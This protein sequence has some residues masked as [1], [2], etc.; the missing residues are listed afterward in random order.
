MVADTN[1]PKTIFLS[2]ASQDA[3]AAAGICA[4]LQSIGLIVWF[5]RGEL[6]GGDAWDASIR[7]QIKECCLFLPIISANTESRLE[8]YFRREWNL[9]AARMLDM[10]DHQAFL[11]PIIIDDTSE[12]NAH[13]PD[14]FRERQ[15]VRLT[16]GQALA[17]LVKRVDQL[18]AGG[19]SSPLTPAYSAPVAASSHNRFST[20]RRIALAIFVMLAVSAIFAW[21][22]R[23]RTPNGGVVAAASSQINESKSI[24]VLPLENLS[25]SPADA[26]LADGLHEEVLNSLARLRDL[27]VISRTS[28]MEYKGKTSNVREI[29][30]RLG[31]GTILEGSIRRDG[32]VLRL[33]VQLIDARDDRHIFAA[34][35]DRDLG[36]LFN[37][38]ST[39]AREVADALAATLSR[40]ERGELDRIATNSGDAYDRYIHAVA[41]FRQPAADDPSGLTGPKRLL[42]EALHFDA[43]YPD[44]LALL[45]QVDTLLFFE[46]GLASNAADA[47]RAFERA[48]AIDPRL[49]EAQLARGLYAM[50]VS[51][52][53]DQALS[54]L[55][56]VVAVRPNSAA[57]HSSL[58][59]ALRR[60]GSL[61]E[62]IG[63][64]A[65]AWDLDPL[66]RAYEGGAIT[67]LIGLRRYPE[68]IE[69]AQLDSKRFPNTPDGYLTCARL[70]AFVQHK[71]EPMRVA[72]REHGGL[73]S[74]SDQRAFEAE[75]A[76][77]EER[78]LDA[79]HAWEDLP[80]TDVLARAERIAFL[81]FAAGDA[82]RAQR[83]FRGLVRIARQMLDG[84]PPQMDTLTRLAIAESMLGE[85]ADALAIIERAR[86]LFPEAADPINGPTVSF[87]RSIILLR[88]GRDAE[89]Y[90]EVRRLLDVPF[91]A[92]TDF[93]ED[94]DPVLLA[95]KDN[96]QYD[97]LIRHPR[98]L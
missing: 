15:W 25:S 51:K 93:F 26:Y 97:E 64:F 23:G 94:P 5:D 62:A 74:Q 52:D 34:N 87:R 2:Y 65:R 19:T 1:N 72:L 73:S 22:W 41:L 11:L 56:A 95:L 3:A 84:K 54:D 14:K 98:R 7:K 33:S 48:L 28:V 82:P 50:Y 35:Y 59:Y 16:D 44:A 29:G 8:G 17:A 30:Q 13:V 36:H 69:Q 57:A 40:Y 76:R 18:V 75:I 38:Q 6:R 68:A 39:V 20:G 60:R 21:A 78:F 45:S 12:A 88:A 31:V 55:T 81:Y 53:L 37:L 66:N 24:A 42:G 49:A 4:A 85:H 32:N 80:T 43:D 46:E 47:K 58:G 9:A 10:A 90:A 67:T 96:S 61:E 89:A 71:A 27:K 79:A 92:P 63:H 77:I 91:A 86:E 70:E 83:G